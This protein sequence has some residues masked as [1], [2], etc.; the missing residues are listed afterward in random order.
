MISQFLGP[1]QPI[2]RC[3]PFVLP[4]FIFSPSPLSILPSVVVV[5]RR[6]SVRRQLVRLSVRPS[7]PRHPSGVRRRPSS[8]VALSIPR[9]PSAPFIIR[10][11]PGTRPCLDDAHRNP[12]SSHAMLA[13][14]AKVNKDRSPFLMAK[15]V[16]VVIVEFPIWGPAGKR[17]S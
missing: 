9:K 17:T 7:V 13:C 10:C 6:P 3:E 16:L 15:P 14:F 8:S 1:E 2:D 11:S 4:L 12:S 5:H